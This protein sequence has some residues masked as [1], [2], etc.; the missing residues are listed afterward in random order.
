MYSEAEN[1][2]SEAADV[3]Y[4]AKDHRASLA[5]C[6]YYFAAIFHHKSISHLRSFV[7]VP[8]IL[9]ALYIL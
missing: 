4:T 9:H 3:G 8:T 1:A 6:G 5:K 7:F 2:L